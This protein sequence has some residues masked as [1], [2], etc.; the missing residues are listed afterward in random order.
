MVGGIIIFELEYGPG[1]FKNTQAK[2]ETTLL[3]KS[4]LDTLSKL[5]ND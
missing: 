5:M 1:N 3:P 2:G 4:F